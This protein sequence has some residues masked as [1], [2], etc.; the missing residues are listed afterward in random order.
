MNRVFRNATLGLT[1]LALTA[2]APGVRAQ[3]A[4]TTRF[5]DHEQK[6]LARVAKKLPM[7]AEARAA[8]DAVLVKYDAKRRAQLGKIAGA[9][10]ALEATYAASP[11]DDAALEAKLEAL[12]AEGRAMHDLRRAK[13]AEL[14]DQ[15]TNLQKLRVVGYMAKRARPEKRRKVGEWVMKHALGPLLRYVVGLD[16][17]AI[18]AGRKVIVAR[19]GNREALREE[20]KGIR[21]EIQAAY[22]DPTTDESRARLVIAKAKVFRE[23][24]KRHTEEGLDA[25]KAA[26]PANQRAKLV[27][28]LAAGGKALLGLVDQFKV[29][30]D[31]EAFR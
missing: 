22:T 15:L 21:A 17:A 14:E 13:M 3:E 29:V 9:L 19:R 10:A 1:A 23:K 7:S 6:I 2:A 4:E 16:P 31:L 11:T 8:S 28:R 30:E 24:V 5:L 12:R 26:V 25:L 20:W 18:E 27:T